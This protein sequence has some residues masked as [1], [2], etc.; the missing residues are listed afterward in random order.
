MS[1]ATNWTGG[2]VSDTTL[3]VNAGVEEVSYQYDCGKGVKPT[4]IFRTSLP[5]N[6][7]N[8]PD[9]NFRKYIKTY[10]AGGRDVL[11]IGRT[12]KSRKVSKSKDGTSAT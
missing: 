8:F 12:K 1:K 11:T 9:P 3:S 10:K 7:K 5:I 4:F 6:E 2:S